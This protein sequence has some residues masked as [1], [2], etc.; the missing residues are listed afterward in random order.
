MQPT[1]FVATSLLASTAFFGSAAY[2]CTVDEI[3]THELRSH[4]LRK[5]LIGNTLRITMLSGLVYF[6]D[7]ENAIHLPPGKYAEAQ[8]ISWQ[9]ND[10]ALACFVLPDISDGELCMQVKKSK[11]GRFFYKRLC[12]N[13]DSYPGVKQRM[14]AFEFGGYS[15]IDSSDLKTGKELSRYTWQC[16]GHLAIAP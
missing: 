4:E 6:I 2:A 15:I 14:P 11:S 3:N 13:T 12:A 9:I 16:F 8:P 7:K 1:R 5:L 10:D